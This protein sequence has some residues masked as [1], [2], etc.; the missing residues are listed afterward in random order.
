M[1][2]FWSNERVYSLN[3]NITD[4]EEEKSAGSGPKI[5]RT[6]GN[7]MERR[8]LSHERERDRKRTSGIAGL[9]K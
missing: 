2:G 5:E 8:R 3:G 4:R 1:W 6:C 7:L 9:L